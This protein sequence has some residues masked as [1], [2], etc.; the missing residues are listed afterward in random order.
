[1]RRLPPRLSNLGKR[2]VCGSKVY[3]RDSDGA[4]VDLVL[5]RPGGEE[6]AV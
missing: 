3:V 1:M 6:W 4:E 5:A 2:L